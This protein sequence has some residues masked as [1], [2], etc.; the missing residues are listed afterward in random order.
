MTT[1]L[2][3]SALAR[4]TGMLLIQVS[5]GPMRY[6]VVRTWDQVQRMSAAGV[7]LDILQDFTGEKN[8]DKNSI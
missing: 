3:L 6:I 7:V 2:E 8:N 1:A 4:K 5:S